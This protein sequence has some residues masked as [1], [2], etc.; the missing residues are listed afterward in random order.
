MGFSP[1]CARSWPRWTSPFRLR[2]EGEARMNARQ[3]TRRVV[4]NGRTYRFRKTPTV[5]VCLDGSEPGYIEE[6]I[7]AGRAPAFARFMAEG[8]NLLADS[9]I[10]SFTNPN[11]LSIIT[12]TP[13]AVHG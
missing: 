12:G 3:A 4:C 7:A 5:V 8:A 10:P 6:T 1:T 11:N 9:V 13:P 2:H